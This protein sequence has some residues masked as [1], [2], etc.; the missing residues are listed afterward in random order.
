MK[1]NSVIALTVTIFSVLILSIVVSFIV[2]I[3]Y[4]QNDNKEKI[5]LEK[6]LDVVELKNDILVQKIDSLE[7]VSN[8]SKI[9]L[10][11][12]NK[13]IKYFDG[14]IYEINQDLMNC[15]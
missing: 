14:Q 10:D 9:F 6:R 13:K 1:A 4:L 15:F 12:V 5:E 7:N 2:H 8:E 11:K 3:E